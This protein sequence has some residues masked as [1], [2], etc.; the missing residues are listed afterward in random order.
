MGDG[1][2]APP[3]VIVAGPGGAGQ[4]PGPQPWFQSRNSICACLASA[5]SY[6]FS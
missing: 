1:G 4:H 3:K 6:V 5:A 2:A